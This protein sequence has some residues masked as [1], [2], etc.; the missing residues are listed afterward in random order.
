MSR[1][2]RVFC[3]LVLLVT[4]SVAQ[5]QMNPGERRLVLV[6][7]GEIF[8]KLRGVKKW[9]V[10]NRRH[11][12]LCSK[13]DRK[14][15]K[16]RRLLIGR[17]G[18]LLD[19]DAN[20]KELLDRRRRFDKLDR[21]IARL[22]RVCSKDYLINVAPIASQ[23]DNQTRAIEENS[24]VR[25]IL[26]SRLDTKT[27][28]FPYNLVRQMVVAFLPQYDRT[29]DLIESLNKSLSSKRKPFLLGKGPTI[30][31]F[32]TIDE[33]KF[34]ELRLGPDSR[35]IRSDFWKRVSSETRRRPPDQSPEEW[36]SKALASLKREFPRELLDG[37]DF[38]QAF[39]SEQNIGLIVMHKS[40]FAIW[41][42]LAKTPHRDITQE[43]ADFYARL[44]A[45]NR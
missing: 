34:L 26:Y 11:D 4:G 19:F 2:V 8:H 27:L 43:Y 31:K 30:E 24:S 16:K 21:E 3:V 38:L 37:M 1:A 42:E 39:A 14:I 33:D 25:F 29:S 10:A 45:G 12:R 15:E 20:W 36:E 18:Q 7:T 41:P 40:A 5:A 9:V 13:A 35:K 17:W 44:V 32:A 22:S 23:I 6:K 28:R